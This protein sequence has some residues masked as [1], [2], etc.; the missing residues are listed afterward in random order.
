MDPGQPDDLYPRLKTSAVAARQEAYAVVTGPRK[1]PEESTEVPARSL[2]A[3]PGVKSAKSQ[4]DS[5]TETE[6]APQ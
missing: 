4:N 2:V 3:D 6:T 1:G 5:L